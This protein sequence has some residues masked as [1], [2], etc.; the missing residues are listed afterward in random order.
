MNCRYC[1]ANIE[2]NSQ[3]CSKCGKQINEFNQICPKCGAPM[4]NDA[5]FCVKC[6]YAQKAKRK[7]PIAGIIIA[8]VVIIAAGIGGTAYYLQQKAVREA[9]EAE[10]EAERQR[11]SAIH[12]YQ[13]K[14]IELYDEINASKSNFD[15]M[16][17]M[18]S[19][20][21]E[22]NTGLLGPT[23]FTSYVE[24]LCSSEISAEKARKREIDSLRSEL[25][26]LGC[27]EP[28]VEEL[29]KSLENYYYSYLERYEL[30]VE[31]DFSTYTFS[32]K[33]S[34]SA[35]DF[36]EKFCTAQEEINKIDRAELEND[37]TDSDEIENK[38]TE[39][40]SIL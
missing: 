4:E 31:G 14:A 5:K 11:Q 19:T 18:Y 23:F 10:L 35:E 26:E 21:T 33:E 24:G 15:I 6:G 1:G 32:S 39:G 8:I 30:L 37:E 2:E 16:S 36:N 22:L 20:S 29:K 12:T 25:N 34:A 13:S 28:E 40:G 17:I 27:D 7:I 38:E 9:Y 3:F